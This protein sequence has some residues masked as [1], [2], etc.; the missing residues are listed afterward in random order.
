MI[1]YD[2]K[3]NITWN[4]RG[5]LTT[6][7]MAGI[8]ELAGVLTTRALLYDDGAGVVYDWAPLEDVARMWCIPTALTDQDIVDRLNLIAGSGWQDP[9][10]QARTAQAT[11]DDA[12]ATADTAAAS[13]NE[14][15][16]ALL[17]LNATNETEAT[18]AE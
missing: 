1:P 9:S 13:M 3:S 4:D 2:G 8:P 5:E 16:D 7:Q 17:G 11:A 10:E 6:D 18:D 14:Y 15:M 12:K